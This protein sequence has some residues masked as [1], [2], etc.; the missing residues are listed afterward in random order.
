MKHNFTKN[1]TAAATP[2]VTVFGDSIPKGLYLEGGRVA[3][4][5]QNAVTLTAEK[6]GLEINNFSIFGQTLKKCFEK[7]HFERWLADRQNLREIPV[8]SL[9]GNDSD[10]DWAAVAAAPDAEHRPFTPL[11]EFENILE[12]LI[13]LLKSAGAAPVFTLLPP[14]DSQR[15]F[16]NVISRRAD[17]QKVLRFFH[18]DVTNIARHQECY[19]AAIARKAAEHNCGCIDIRTPLLWQRDYLDL[20]ADDGVHP[21]GKGHALIAETVAEYIRAN[22]PHLGQVC[23]S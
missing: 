18:G 9:G 22:Y 12:R 19:S 21:N 4:V 3:R 14:I 11:G 20:I 5:G 17:G 16:E 15:Y 1:N 8:I 10:Y 2:R 6:F 13:C 7:G 23:A